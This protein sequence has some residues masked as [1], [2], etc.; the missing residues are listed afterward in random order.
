MVRYEDFSLDPINNTRKIFDFIGFNFSQE[1]NEFLESHTKTERQ[2]TDTFR[3]TKTAP[4][5][6]TE[7]FNKT[8]VLKIQV[9]RHFIHLLYY[10]CRINV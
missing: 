9:E 10:Y 4:F 2:G 5:K 7:K 6:W 3:D 1:M 8:E